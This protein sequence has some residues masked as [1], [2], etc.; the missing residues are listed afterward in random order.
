MIFCK[1]ERFCND[2]C[3]YCLA[4]DDGRGA[5]GTQIPLE[6][7]KKV[8]VTAVCSCQVKPDA[9]EGALRM[10]VI[11]TLVLPFSLARKITEENLLT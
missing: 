10:R 11:D 4:G 3:V 8:Q 7:L 1:T 6:R 2:L 9:L 5:R